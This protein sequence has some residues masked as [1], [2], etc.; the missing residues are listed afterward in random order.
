[1]VAWVRATQSPKWHLD[2]FSCFCTAQAGMSLY[3]T[4]GRP[5]TPKIASFHGDADMVPWARPSAQPKRHLD[6]FSRFCRAHYC[7]RPRD[8]P[9]DHATRSIT[10]GHIVTYEVRPTVVQP[11]NNSSTTTSSY[12]SVPTIIAFIHI[13]MFVDCR[14]QLSRKF[15]TSLLQPSSCLHILLPTPRDPIITTRL[16]S[17]NKFPRLPSRTRKYQTFLSYALAHYQTS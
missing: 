2:R 16:R 4:I 9:I 13:I 1:M 10:T 5:Y 8:K 3:F 14:E 12:F 17:A 6:R 7:E 15:F 11:N